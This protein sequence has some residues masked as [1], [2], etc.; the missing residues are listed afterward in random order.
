MKTLL[1]LM[2]TPR[3]IPSFVRHELAFMWPAFAA[4]LL[5]AQTCVATPGGWDFTNSL[6]S[7]REKHTATLLP[8]GQ[9]LV[10][11]GRSENDSASVTAE[12][13]DPA[14]G[15]WSFTGSLTGQRKLHSA[16]LLPSGLVLVA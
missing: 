9:V 8:N 2:T 14:A 4:G 11:G 13:Y 1:L 5:L 16:T 3:S 6:P 10:G 7:P 15:L 12:L